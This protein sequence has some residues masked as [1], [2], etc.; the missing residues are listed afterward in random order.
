M[1]HAKDDLSALFCILREFPQRNTTDAEES[2]EVAVN[3]EP[4][5]VV[6]EM[7]LVET[8]EQAYRFCGRRRDR[9]E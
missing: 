4:E 2:L 3:T 7:A 5:P 1:D 9:F 6:D 8:E